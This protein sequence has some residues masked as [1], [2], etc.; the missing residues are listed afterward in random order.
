[1]RGVEEGTEGMGEKKGRKEGTGREA[2]W[3]LTLVP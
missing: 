1:M 2:F 3:L